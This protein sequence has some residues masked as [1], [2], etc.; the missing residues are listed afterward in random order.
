MARFPYWADN[1]FATREI[2]K[3]FSH[4]REQVHKVDSEAAVDLRSVLASIDQCE[5]DLGRA[6]LKLHAVVDVL[7]DKGLVTADELAAKAQELDAMDG[8]TDGILHPAIFRTA[9]ERERTPSPR[10]FLIAL[11]KQPTNPKAFLA[12]LERGE[13]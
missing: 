9:E 12:Q 3:Q 13:P 7:I 10:A 5:V 8:E 1:W 4:L 2:R 11:E 6:L